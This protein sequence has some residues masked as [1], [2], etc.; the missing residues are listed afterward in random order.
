MQVDE[1]EL[2]PQRGRQGL[3]QAAAG[4]DDFLADAVAGDEANSEHTGGHGSGLRRG[5]SDDKAS[6]AWETRGVATGSP[7]RE[8]GGWPRSSAHANEGFSNCLPIA[9]LPL[10]TSAKSRRLAPAV[11]H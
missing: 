8:N 1:V 10:P 7:D 3:E 5:G 11:A 9:H 6:A 4:G 2:E